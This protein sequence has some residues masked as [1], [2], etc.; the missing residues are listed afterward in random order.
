[1]GIPTTSQFNKFV[2]RVCLNILPIVTLSFILLSVSDCKESK[3]NMEYEVKHTGALRSI[4]SGNLDATAALDSL[5]SRSKLYAL[6][7]F[8]N[9]KG[10]LQIFDG[11]SFN[12]IV[13]DSAV[14]IDPNFD[15]KATLLV[16]A[17]V[18]EWGAIE[19]P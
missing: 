1:M 19:T 18:P 4:M 12:S 2:S 5:E 8:E 15:R 3:H 9:L 14:V 16:Y 10:E 7:A 17:Q 13:K 11:N 6:G